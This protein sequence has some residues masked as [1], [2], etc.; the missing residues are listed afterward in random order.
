MESVVKNN[1]KT[2]VIK[3]IHNKISKWG[4]ITASQRLSLSIEKLI[5]LGV[6]NYSFNTFLT[7][8]DL[9]YLS[10]FVIEK[11]GPISKIVKI[12]DNEYDIIYWAGIQKIFLDCKNLTSSNSIPATGIPYFPNEKYID[13]YPPSFIIKVVLEEDYIFNAIRKELK[14]ITEFKSFDEFES[15]ILNDMFDLMI[16]AISEITFKD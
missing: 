8:D 6:F 7:Y 2:N 1:E 13:I 4:V 10:L 15:Y 11:N 12:N 16:D 5:D 9:H 14:P 3:L